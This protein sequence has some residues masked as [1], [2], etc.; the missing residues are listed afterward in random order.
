MNN[1]QEI[2]LNYNFF[3]YFP[4]FDEITENDTVCP[5]QYTTCY[6]VKYSNSTVVA[7]NACV[8]VN[9][10]ALVQLFIDTCALVQCLVSITYVFAYT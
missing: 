2:K 7:M 8:L 4:L 3:C 6:E 10:C 1:N 9:L 5:I